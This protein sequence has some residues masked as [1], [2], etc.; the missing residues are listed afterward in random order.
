MDVYKGTTST[1]AG[2][3]CMGNFLKYTDDGAIE[4]SLLKNA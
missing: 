1:R 2:I 4:A 3:I